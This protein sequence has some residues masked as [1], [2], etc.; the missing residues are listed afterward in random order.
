LKEIIIIIHETRG[1][2]GVVNQDIFLIGQS[3]LQ[4]FYHTQLSVEVCLS[5]FEKRAQKGGLLFKITYK[6]T[7][8]RLGWYGAYAYKLI[9]LVL[10][11][12]TSMH[13]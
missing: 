4:G 2:Q 1:E 10:S 7:K 5:G 12:Y 11:L 8:R 3:T 9:V 6:K 13:V